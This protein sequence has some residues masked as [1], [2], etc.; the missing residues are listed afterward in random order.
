M[1]YDTT[2][3]DNNNRYLR[4][5]W[6][7]NSTTGRVEGSG[8]NIRDNPN[9]NFI[10]IIKIITKEKKTLIE[11]KIVSLLLWKHEKIGHYARFINC[12]TNYVI[13]KKILSSI[14]P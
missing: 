8:S 10:E 6:P 13:S 9:S 11:I 2:I 12:T 3:I 4:C 7:H 14:F 5:H 1:K